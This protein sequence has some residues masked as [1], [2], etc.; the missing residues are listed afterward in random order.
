MVLLADTG[1]NTAVYNID[2]LLCFRRSYYTILSFYFLDINRTVSLWR[3]WE[4][5]A[6][7]DFR[8]GHPYT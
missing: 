8:V 2:I 1:Y 7:R 4:I 3:N 5:A 6:V